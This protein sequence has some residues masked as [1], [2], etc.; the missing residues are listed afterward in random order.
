MIERSPGLRSVRLFASLVCLLAISGCSLRIADMSLISTRNVNLDRVDIDT[1]E[2]TQVEGS[3]SGWIFLFI[4]FSFP[5][6]EN[7]IDVALNR[8]GGD[9]MTDAVVHA[10]GWWFIVGQQT[11]RVEGTVVNTRRSSRGERRR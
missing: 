11:I 4:P 6:L 9:L 1:L 5:H 3:D 2:G 7:A 8:A 10:S